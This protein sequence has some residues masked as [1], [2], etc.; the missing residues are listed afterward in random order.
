M[1]F[2]VFFSLCFFCF[3]FFLFNASLCFVFV[4]FLLVRVGEVP[5][6]SCLTFFVLA[7][8][9]GSIYIYFFLAGLFFVV[10]LLPGDFCIVLVFFFVCFSDI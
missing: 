10:V 2:V 7:C 5:F 8:R 1:P 9:L 3:H 6:F 4:L